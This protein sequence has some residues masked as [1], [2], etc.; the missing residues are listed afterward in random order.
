[1]SKKNFI[2][3]LIITVFIIAICYIYFASGKPE[4]LSIIEKNTKNDLD[5]IIFSIN[6]LDIGNHSLEIYFEPYDINILRQT[7]S[8]IKFDF[9][10]EILEKRKNETKQKHISIMLE[11]ATIG[12]GISLFNVPRD[13]F[14][15]HNTDVK[16]TI[17]NFKYDD[18]FIQYYKR[19]RIWVQRNALFFE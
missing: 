4:T 15:N 6:K 2:L 3:L 13:F 7:D 19:I 11:K 8:P 18:I 14:W 12:V 9:D 5:Q 16:I 17:S 10:V 1:M